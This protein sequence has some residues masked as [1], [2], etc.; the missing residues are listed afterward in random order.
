MLAAVLETL[1]GNPLAA[2]DV[3][4][5]DLDD[6]H[7]TAPRALDELDRIRQVTLTVGDE[8][9]IEAVTRRTG[10]QQTILDALEVDTRAW[11]R[12]AIH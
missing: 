11:N 10:L 9:T 6:Q 8:T 2:A 7:L 3:R 12:P 4:D 1:I 5:P